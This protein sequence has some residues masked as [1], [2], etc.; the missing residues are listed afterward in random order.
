MTAAPPSY[1][2]RSGGSDSGGGVVDFRRIGDHSQSLIF[3]KLHIGGICDC[4]LIEPC[5]LIGMLP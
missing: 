5:I 1:N 4:E 3:A 2:R